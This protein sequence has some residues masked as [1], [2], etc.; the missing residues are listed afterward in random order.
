MKR[1]DLIA[2]KGD[3]PRGK[4]RNDA[5]VSPPAR[6]KT[7]A[8]QKWQETAW[9]KQRAETQRWR[10]E[11]RPH[12]LRL[13]AARTAQLTW[14]RSLLTVLLDELHT[15]DLFNELVGEPLTLPVRRYPQAVAVAIAL[16]HSWRRD[17]LSR[18]VKRV[19][20]PLART[21]RVAPQS[22]TPTPLS[23]RASTLRVSKKSS[24]R[25]VR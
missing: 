9:A 18:L 2:K 16:R 1:R 15:N 5:R 3:R 6:G 20:V 21:R 7:H 12:T 23:R 4:P 14:S 8:T 10:R 17:D 13:I 19:G 25:S 24:R 22:P 11:R